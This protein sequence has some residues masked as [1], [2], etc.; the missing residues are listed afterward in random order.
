MGQIYPLTQPQ[1]SGSTAAQQ[2][3]KSADGLAMAGSE[4]E[5]ENDA[6]EQVMEA[7]RVHFKLNTVAEVMARLCE[8]A[9]ADV[10]RAMKRA[11]PLRVVKGKA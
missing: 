4:V 7:L 5:L 1:M 6:A 10:S 8:P 9:L 3:P 11:L 2:L